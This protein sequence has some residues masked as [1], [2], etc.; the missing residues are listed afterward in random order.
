MLK[1]EKNRKEHFSRGKNTPLHFN[2][3]KK[4]VWKKNNN[5]TLQEKLFQNNYSFIDAFTLIHMRI[6]IVG[7]SFMAAPPIGSTRW[8]LDVVSVS[9]AARRGP[10]A[11]RAG[12]GQGVAPAADRWR[13]RRPTVAKV[14]FLNGGVEAGDRMNLLDFSVDWI[15]QIFVDLK[16][17]IFIYFRVN[18]KM[19]KR[20]IDEIDEIELGV[21]S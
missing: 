11:E 12:G 7:G 17:Y 21:G 19:E 18:L 4:R 5:K 14:A 1:E 16:K 6:I 2:H 8:R 3:K 9:A 10:A 13:N 15:Y 20:L